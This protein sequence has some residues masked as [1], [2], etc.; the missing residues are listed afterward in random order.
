MKF[1]E[2]DFEVLAARVEKLESR[3][4]RWKAVSIVIGLFAASLI[5]M[6]ARLADRIDPSVIRTTT[7]EAREVVLKDRDGHVCARLSVTPIMERSSNHGTN[8]SERTDLAV[9]EIYDEN[10]RAVWTAP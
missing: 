3:H 9:L 8:A 4:R 10:G 6:G 7:I 1:T 5:A 2:T